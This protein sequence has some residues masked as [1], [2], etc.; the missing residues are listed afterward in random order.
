MADKAMG[1]AI[2]GETATAAETGADEQSGPAEMVSEAAEARVS[3]SGTEYQAAWVEMYPCYLPKVS[4]VL[5]VW[6][7][8][9][10]LGESIQSVLNQTYPNLELIVVDDGS[11]QDLGPVLSQFSGD[12]RLRLLRRQHEGLPQALNAGFRLAEGDFW[13]WTSADNVMGPEMLAALLRFLL[14]NPAVDMTY[15]D[16]ELISSTGDALT[17]SSYHLFNQRVG[18]SNE[19]RLSRSVETLGLLDDNFIGR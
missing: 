5:P 8:A 13:T 10:L 18:A 12:P 3:V 1:D 16:M 7:Q 6:N 15:G 19:L 17:G 4:V 14:L 2:A 9:D 11:T